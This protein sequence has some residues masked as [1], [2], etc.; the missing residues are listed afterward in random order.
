MLLPLNVCVV[1]QIFHLSPLPKQKVVYAHA[2]KKHLA[3]AMPTLLLVC[4][5]RAVLVGD[6]WLKLMCIHLICSPEYWYGIV[7]LS[8]TTTFT[9]HTK[10]GKFV[11]WCV[12]S[13]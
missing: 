8:S 4:C 7:N 3:P 12:A 11:F 2:D 6:P 13:L 10:A 9:S 5:S 1:E